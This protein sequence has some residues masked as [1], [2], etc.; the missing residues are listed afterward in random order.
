LTTPKA[1][2]PADSAIGNWQS[3]IGTE[4]TL[5][6]ITPTRLRIKGEVVENPSF[7]QIITSFSLRLSMVAQT[8][9][10]ESLSY[11]H[12]AMIERARDVSIRKSTVSLMAL[13][14]FS[15]RRRLKLAI[16]GF[17]GEVTFSGEAIREL[18][19]LVVAGEFL[20]VGSGT[21]FGMGR[22]VVVK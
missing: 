12:K 17:M 11:D 13:D 4:I 18:L 7:A 3:A 2:Q 22:Y 5:R 1:G 15:N 14:R 10:T 21:A 6:F 8:C 19:P 9:G 20:H 16:D